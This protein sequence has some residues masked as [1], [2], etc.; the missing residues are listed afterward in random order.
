MNT[1]PSIIFPANETTIVAQS[2]DIQM[3]NSFEND[4]CTVGPVTETQKAV[5]FDSE[6][7][8]GINAEIVKPR[9]KMVHMMKWALAGLQLATAIY[10]WVKFAEI[11]FF[12]WQA[13]VLTLITVS[14]FITLIRAKSCRRTSN[15]KVPFVFWVAGLVI[16]LATLGLVAD[17]IAESIVLYSRQFCYKPI[18]FLHGNGI[19]VHWCT[20]FK[21]ESQLYSGN[22]YQQTHK[23]NFHSVQLSN[24]NAKYS[25]SGLDE[26]FQIALPD[27]V[28]KFVVMTDIH[29]NN[30][31]TSALGTDFDF[32]VFCGDQSNN[33]T[34][35]EFEHSFKNLPQKPVIMA[36]GNH[37]ARGKFD[38]VMQR[39]VNFYQQVRNV[40]F[41][42]IFIQKGTPVS[43]KKVDIAMQFLRD[44]IHLSAGVEHVF[45]VVHY[46]VYSTGYFGAHPYFS[47]S[48]E[49]F[50]DANTDKKIRSVFYGHDHNFA[51]F[52]RNNQ[53]FFDTGVGGGHITMMNKTKNGKERKWPSDSLHGPLVPINDKCYGYEHHLDSW[54]LYSRTEVEI[55]AGKI[56]YHV[57]DLVRD[58]ILKSYEQIL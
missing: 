5:Q 29:A 17:V 15:T 58:T 52:Q 37:D 49:V 54:L 19:R 45:V 39:D 33:G 46:P 20:F 55:A 47:K 41:Y 40:G 10:S 31:F 53:Y 13:I 4:L 48:L 9:S 6:S 25:I 18:A 16:T 22:N 57:R 27:K 51:A 30:K 56:V 12:L 26:S 28:S 1:Q 42:F 7:Q 34:I 23:G 32:M 44:N 11:G 35:N 43:D 36:M 24:F 2:I 38:Q 8:Q 14:S 50:L 21:Q 3:S